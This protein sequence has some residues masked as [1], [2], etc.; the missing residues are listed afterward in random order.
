MVYEQCA[1]CIA[2]PFCKKYKGEIEAT[3]FSDWCPEYGR[4][5][6]ALELSRLPREYHEANIHTYKVD[7]ANEEVFNKLK[8]IALDALNLV[9]NQMNLLITGAGCGVGK[10][11]N[12]AVVLN[13]YMYKRCL[14]D[15]DY[16]TPIALFVDYTQFIN[17]LRD[18]DNNSEAKALFEQMKTVPLLLLDDVGSGIMSRFTR[19]QTYII[20][21]SRYNN[22]L[23][24]IITSN[25]SLA[26]LN[27]DDYLGARNLSRLTRNSLWIEMKGKDRR[28]S[29]LK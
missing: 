8:P 1:K 11:F 24:T 12:G 15:F 4:L 29:L 3:G 5:S 20:L 21:N 7:D 2:K 19:E 10:T 28:R 16:E 22:N 17:D 9:Y 14:L 26:T 13:H 25:I 6:K 27:T 18:F 23:S